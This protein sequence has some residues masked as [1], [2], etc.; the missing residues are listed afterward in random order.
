MSDENKAINAEYMCWR[1]NISSLYSMMV[2]HSIEWPALSVQFYPDYTRTNNLTTQRLLIS[3]HTSG[4]DQEYLHIVELTL[5]DTV[6]D[7]ETEECFKL[8]IVQ[9]IALSTEVNR[10]RYSYLSPNLIA[11]RSDEKEVLVFDS[12]THLSNEKACK[13]DYI[14]K[15]HEAGGYGLDWSFFESNILLS[16]GEDKKIILWDITKNSSNFFEGHKGVVN[17]INFNKINLNLF[18]SVG[19]SK[20]MIL[21]DKRMNN[22]VKV[23]E[24]H[25]SDILCC[26]FNPLEENICATGSADS[27]LKVWDIRNLDNALFNLI[28]HKKE[29]SVVRWSPHVSSLLA[30]GSYDRRVI[31][32]DLKRNTLVDQEAPSEMLFMHAGHT[33][34]I[35]D[36]AWNPLEKYELASTAEDNILQIWSRGEES[37]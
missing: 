6:D 27:S 15:G 21:W 24:A 37:V 29:I 26:E 13:P 8:K 31:L 4:Q 1:K 7:A 20:Q 33:N 11:V 16:C 25:S 32:W 14:L 10:A 18:I 9:K 28:G 23:L 35:T 3:P 36:I 19:D 17:D 12:T 34:V 30:S 5:P 22:P 2:N